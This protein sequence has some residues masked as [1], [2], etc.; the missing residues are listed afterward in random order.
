MGVTTKVAALRKARGIAAATLAR[1]AGVS[2]Q[3][4][5]AIEAESYIPNTAI[6]LRLA[7]ELGASVE[8]LFSLSAPKKHAVKAEL[9]G[10][11][12]LAQG[13]AVN[14]CRVDQTWIAAPLCPAPRFLSDSN[15]VVARAADHEARIF[16]RLVEDSEA[17]SG[18][19]VIAGCDPALGFLQ[20]LAARKGVDVVAVPAS[21]RRALE[22][23]RL[24]RIHIAGSHLEDPATGDFNSSFVAGAFPK[25]RMVL[26]TYAL[27]R[28]GLVTAAGNPK[29]IR[30]LDD[31][32]RRDVRFINREPGSGSRDQLDRF[33][34]D[35]GMAPTK[36]RGYSKLADGHL[37]AAGAVAQAAVD[38]CI[39]TE[40]AA[41]AF[42]L[43]FI[44]LKTERFDFVLRHDS[45]ETT[46]VRTV[47]DLLQHA[48]LR[49]KLEQ[50]AGYD[51]RQT[52]RIAAG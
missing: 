52:G 50:I 28:E 32:E 42:G 30:G 46:A 13:Q 19:L 22:W 24:R 29:Q 14:A 34:A 33:I 31:L 27:W 25:E 20:S 9:L 48:T 26:I 6:A 11:G 2:R 37:A 21:S 16:V 3:T 8:D 7:R 45:L 36:I 39:A 23:L 1:K 38:C 40:S 51:V 35:A 47:L 18:Q 4:I 43:G 5:Y 10:S 17:R 44:A 15:A 12:G 41:R 49:G